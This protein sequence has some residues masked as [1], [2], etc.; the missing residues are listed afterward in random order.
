MIKAL[1][2]LLTPFLF[3]RFSSGGYRLFYLELAAVYLNRVGHQPVG[4]MIVVD[5]EGDRFS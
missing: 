5:L 2:N 3:L 1:V 4:T